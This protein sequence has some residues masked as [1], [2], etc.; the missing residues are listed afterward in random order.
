MSKLFPLGL[1]R[2]QPLGAG[3]AS[4]RWTTPAWSTYPGQVVAD[5]P[6]GVQKRIELVRALQAEPKLLLLDEPAAGLNR[7]RD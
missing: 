2:Q 3:G 5:L 1:L 7:H 4:R 6:Y